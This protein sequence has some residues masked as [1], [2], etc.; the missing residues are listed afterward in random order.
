MVEPLT[1]DYAKK[2]AAELDKY[3]ELKDEVYDLSRKI[4]KN[5]KLC[6]FAVRR[7]NMEE[8]KRYIDEMEEMRKRLID[9]AKEN[10]RLSTI[11]MIFNADQEYVE[12]MCVYMFMKDGRLPRLEEVGTSVQEY[13][14]GVMDAAGELLRIATD[15]MIANDLDFA[16]RVKEVIEEIYIF[17]LH[18][19]PRDYELRRKIDY[20]SNILNKLQEFIFYKEVVGPVKTI[21]GSDR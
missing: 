4:I 19:N 1:V 20:V 8:A 15:K 16:K 21:T 3:D 10:P 5:S 12:A 11:N 9:I 7:G 2:L 6:I 17:M 18:V 14:A 13:I